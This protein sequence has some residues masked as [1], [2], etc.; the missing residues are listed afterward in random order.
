MA[1]ATTRYTA[2]HPCPVCGGHERMDR[3]N[4]KRCHGFLGSDGSVFCSREQYKG[5]LE[6]RNGLYLH[7]LD[8]VC[9]CGANHRNGAQQPAQG[10]T[11]EAE[12]IYTDHVGRPLYKVIRYKEPKGF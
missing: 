9:P 2:L 4:G 1:S 3:G 8:E 5:L 6:G 10:G 12:Y 11:V 7:I